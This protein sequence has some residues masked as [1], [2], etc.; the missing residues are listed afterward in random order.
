MSYGT[1]VRGGWV[2]LEGQGLQEVDL[3]LRD[4]K[5]VGIL[6]PGESAEA[7]EIIDAGGLVVLPGVVDAH[8]HFGMGSSDDWVTESRA[9]V[10]GGVTCV[11]NYVMDARS[12][13]E[14]GPEE[15]E[16]AERE[17]V[18]DFGTHFILMN[19]QHLAEVPRYIK[20]LGVAS[21]KYFSNFKGNE[22]AYL[23]VT[24]TDNGFFYD[25]TRVVAQY[26]EA[27]LAVHTE[28][29]EVVWRLAASLKAAGRDGLAAW[30]ESRP[31]FVE[32]HDMFTA[33]LFAEQTGCR[34][35]IPHL[36]SALGLRTYR[37]H[38]ARGG[39]SWVETCPHYLTHTLGS[40]LGTLV[41]VNPPVREQKDADALWQAV[42][43]GSVA[44]VASD[45]NSRKRVKK[46]GTIW[47]ASAGFPGVTTL[48]PVLLSE[49]HHKRGIPL[50]R[51]AELVSTNPA[52]IFGLYPKKGSISV[53]A[54]ADLTLVDLDREQVVDSSS[55]GSHADYSIYDGWRLRG[56]P[57]TAV[58]RGRVVMHEGE[59]L[60][61]GGYGR[62]I[63][64]PVSSWTASDAPVTAGYAHV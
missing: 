32:A 8:V 44:V 30:N 5:I 10:H 15:R 40:E 53:G 22:G 63:P 37:E 47:S 60:V 13:L 38:L 24:G 35:Y 62:Y 28:N 26:P 61:P 43:D 39:R 3:A 20:E 51:V 59:V 31:D 54:D 34:T 23:G 45:H 4:G 41:K 33:F 16:V 64:R 50:E 9:A 36:S 25:L 17:S 19:D 6:E 2:V 42:A 46:E 14:V 1:L 11:L 7:E 48:L 56:W 29:I 21:F 52:R 49:C 55:F 18:I 27:V 58:V 12:Y 57:V